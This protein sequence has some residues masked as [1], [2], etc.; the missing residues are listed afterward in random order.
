[1]M[2]PLVNIKNNR[3]KLV[4]EFNQRRGAFMVL[5]AIC[6]VGAVGFVALSVDI[7]VLSLTKIN[8]QKAVDAAALAAAQE[9]IA[10]I[11][12]AGDDGQTVGG[13]TSAGDINSIAI[14]SAKLMAE[15]VAALNGVYVDPDVDVAFGRRVFNENLQRFE[16]EWGDAPYSGSA[17]YNVVQVTARRTNPDTTLPDGMVDLFFAPIGG[18]DKAA[19][20]AS[21]IAFVEARDIVSVLDYSGSMNYDSQLSSL[22]RFGRVALEGNIRDIYDAL[23]PLDLGCLEF[24]PEWLTVE[25]EDPDEAGEAKI[26]V[27]FRDDEIDVTSD[28]E[29]HEVYIIFEGGG[30]QHFQN[31]SGTFRTYQ[32]SGDDDDRSIHA[33]YIRSGMTAVTVSGQEEQGKNIPHIQV[34]FMENSIYV[35]ST[36]DLSN[37]V[38]EFTDGVHQK[39]EGLSGHT[40]TFLGTGEN[41]GKAIVNAWI[42]SGKNFSGDGPGYG[43]SFENPGGSA[44]EYQYFEDNN[45]N[46]KKAFCLDITSYPYNSGNWDKY[47]DYVRTSAQVKDAGYRKK[48]GGLNFVDYLLS[49]QPRSS[50][51]EDLW[52]TPH[53]PFHAM[54]NGMSLF[55]E[56]LE[57][58]DFGDHAGIATYD[59]TSRVEYQV[60][61]ENGVVLRDLGTE[62]ITDDYES[63]DEIQRRKQ[64][65]HYNVYTGLG[66]GIEEAV[67]LL[68]T[69]AR[70][71]SRPTLIVMTDGNANR[72]P[73]GWSLPSNWNWNE[74]T[75]FDDDGTADYTTWDRHKQYAFYQAKLAIDKGYTIHTLSVGAGADRDLMRAMAFAGKGEWINVPGGTTIAEVEEQMLDAFSRIAANVPPAKL[76]NNVE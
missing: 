32:G 35:E 74:L 34:T 19:V 53:Y 68:D 63:L 38:L 54:K 57:D 44:I 56:F 20:M 12:S 75:D 8:L 33:A 23:Q 3:R 61:N 49:Q 22:N 39:F 29:I 31:Q 26:Y 14:D 59:S 28:K 48:Y 17:A 73:S 16:V 43:E 5:A 2:N 62:W 27:K 25:G 30:Y 67:N 24:T 46:V 15:K 9:I 65:G 10:V 51:T 45:E 66:Y 72:S 41:E 52:K 18:N 70:P 47:I 42:K 4:N 36:K 71:G 6:L 13:G 21:A 40:G 11:D 37:V 64:A 1:M 76:L 58:L 50:Q 69:Q 7:G 60:K 55:L